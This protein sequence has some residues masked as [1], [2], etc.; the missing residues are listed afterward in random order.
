MSGKPAD[1]T[2]ASFED[3]VL[4]AENAVLVDFADTGVADAD[5]AHLESLTNLERLNLYYTDVTDAGLERLKGLPKLAWLNVQITHVS[6]EGVKKL[7]KAL[8]NCEIRHT[9]YADQFRDPEQTDE[10]SASKR[11]RA[12]RP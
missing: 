8:P 10:E 11:T 4:K 9:K 7:Q 2:D 3:Q 5:L 6:Y 12:G 1:V